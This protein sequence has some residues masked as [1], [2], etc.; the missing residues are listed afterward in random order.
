MLNFLFSSRITFLFIIFFLY[1]DPRGGK[2]CNFITATDDIESCENQYSIDF[3]LDVAIVGAGHSGLS[4]G[5]RLKA[6]GIENFLIFEKEEPGNAWKNRYDRLH[7][8]TVKSISGLPY[9]GFPD[10]FDEWVA[11]DDLVR[12]YKAYSNVMLPGKVQTKAQVLSATLDHEDET[13]GR[14]NSYTWKLQVEDSSKAITTYRAKVLILATGQE[15]APYIPTFDNQDL[16]LSSNP[17]HTVFHSQYY[18]NPENHWANPQNS[19][20][21]VVG[22]GNSGSEIA[23]DLAQS[24]VQVDVL[25]RSPLTLLPRWLIGIFGNNFKIIRR[26][27]MWMH[28]LVGIFIGPFLFGGDFKTMMPQYFGMPNHRQASLIEDLWY[29]HRAP[30]I[31]IG[32]Y[33]YIKNGTIRVINQEIASFTT[34]GIRFKNEYYTPIT[35]EEKEKLGTLLK[36]EFV[37]E[38]KYDGVILATG[39]QKGKPSEILNED[40]GNCLVDKEYDVLKSGK[41]GVELNAGRCEANQLYF[42]GRN[43]FLGRLAEANLET[44]F[45]LSDMQRKGYVSI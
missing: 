14:K 33:E 11:K 39:F 17:N 3:D 9:F 32:T 21:L 29:R 24:G 37:T 12:Y 6:A 23:L 4:M 31:D 35:E 20:V 1:R 16:F 7:L 10:T 42:V 44:E 28:D 15:S 8:H 41:E 34:D 25:I 2:T 22:Y 26:L 27:P 38:A 13:D 30:L 18:T 5:G 19:R 40:L 43:D 36:R 45:I